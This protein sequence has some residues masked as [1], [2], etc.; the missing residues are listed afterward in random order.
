ML[1]SKLACASTMAGLVWM[2]S[3]AMGS[4]CPVQDREHPTIKRHPIQVLVEQ[5]MDL[6]FYVPEN[7]VYTIDEGCLLEVTGAPTTIVTR[8]TKTETMC[9]MVDE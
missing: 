9:T 1:S 7:T 2:A 5:P 6:S 3:P 8:V 4:R